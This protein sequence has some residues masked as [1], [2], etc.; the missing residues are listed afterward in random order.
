MRVIERSHRV[1]KQVRH[2]ADDS[3]ALLAFQA[4]DC[5][6]SYENARSHLSFV[7]SYRTANTGIEQDV[8]A[9]TAEEL[10]QALG[11]ILLQ[12]R[13]VRLAS[14]ERQARLFHTNCKAMTVKV[15]TPDDVTA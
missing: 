1:F 13:R 3:S 14:L 15:S 6:T 5:R 9:R 10:Q 7:C 12:W 2:L 11:R 8:Q 4:L